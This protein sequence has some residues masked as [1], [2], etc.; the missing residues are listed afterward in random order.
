MKAHR[1]KSWSIKSQL[2]TTTTMLQCRRLKEEKAKKGE[3]K[4]LLFLLVSFNDHLDSSHFQ[5]KIKA[6]SGII[7]KVIWYRNLATQV[8][9]NLRSQMKDREASFYQLR[10]Y[11]KRNFFQRHG[12]VGTAMDVKILPTFSLENPSLLE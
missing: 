5:K 6:T 12:E 1:I 10:Y 2:R 4:P 3:P 8:M 11:R 7:S 9:G